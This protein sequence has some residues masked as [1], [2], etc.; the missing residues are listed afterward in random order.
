[1]LA[2]ATATVD[3]GGATAKGTVMVEHL[4]PQDPGDP[5]FEDFPAWLTPIEE[6]LDELLAGTE[7]AYACIPCG[8]VPGCC[9]NQAG[10]L[11]LNGS[12]WICR[13]CPVF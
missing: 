10:T 4:E 9:L 1:M 11:C 3:D 6:V 8:C 13:A 5:A 12:G 7:I 2:M